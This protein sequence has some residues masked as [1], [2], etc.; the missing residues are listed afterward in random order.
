M[1]PTA[2]DS[3]KQRNQGPTPSHLPPDLQDPGQRNAR[4]GVPL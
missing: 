4:S 3:A 2:D 1:R